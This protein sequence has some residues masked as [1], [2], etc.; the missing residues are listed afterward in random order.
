MSKKPSVWFW[1]QTFTPHMGALSAALAKRGFK[2]FFVANKRLSKKRLQLGW[3][4]PALGKQILI[5]APN[6]HIVKQIASKA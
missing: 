5:L 4:T 6:K 1:Q 3:E 2:V